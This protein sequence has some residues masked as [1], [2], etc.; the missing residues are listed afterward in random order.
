MTSPTPTASPTKSSMTSTP[1]ASPTKSSMTS[2]TPTASPTKSSITAPTKS[3]IKSS[4]RKRSSIDIGLI[5]GIVLS[6]AVLISAIVTVIMVKRSQAIKNEAESEKA[7]S[8]IE[9]PE[10][11]MQFRHSEFGTMFCNKIRN[12]YKETC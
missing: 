2:L 4:K 12:C 5:V 8:S 11:N 3:S 1:T 10:L 9:Q 7:K 6:V